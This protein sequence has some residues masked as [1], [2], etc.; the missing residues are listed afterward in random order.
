MLLFN[1][2]IPNQLQNTNKQIS[3]QISNIEVLYMLK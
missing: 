3:N 1:Y 2:F